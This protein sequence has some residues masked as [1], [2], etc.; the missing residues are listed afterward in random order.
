ME[1]IGN[2]LT[3]KGNSDKDCRK[4]KEFVMNSSKL[5]A[6]ALVVGSSTMYAAVDPVSNWNTVAVQATLTA[7]ESAV[8]QSRT[9]AIVHVAI[10]DA[11]N[12]IDSRYERYAFNA[13]V[14]TG[15]S[16][17]AAIAAAARD[18]LVGAI[19]VGPLP[20]PQFGTPALQA[21][22][23]SQVN[24][25]YAMALAGIPDGAA[26]S[27]GITLGQ[28]AAAAILAL[29]STDHATTLV[30]YTPDTRPGDWQPTPD[31]VPFDP[32]AAADFLPA[33]LPG[34]GQ[35]TPFVLRRSTQFEPDGPPRLSG[36]RYARDY[37][38]VKMIGEKNSAIRTTEQTSIAR[39]WYENSPASW[40]RI[41]IV[42]AHSQ[43]LN[44]WDTA[45]LLALINLAMADGFIAGFETKYDFNF[46][47]PVTAIRAGDTDSNDATIADPNWSSLLNTPAIPDFTS[48]HSV[49]GG[50][51]SEVLRQYF[52]N[53]D[54]PFT[55]TSGVPFA[56][57]T[58]SFSSFSQAA[59]ENGES[60]IYAG[61][62]F[63]SAV[64]DGIQQ[65][66]KI[67]R[68]V[69]THALQPLDQ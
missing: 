48:T 51:T 4:A 53:D 55:T 19:A 28:A 45:R 11:L 20:F 39:F 68:F 60:R 38:E 36:R 13:D 3:Q 47:R 17:D 65:G 49:L 30:T 31:P 9:L 6:I 56:G 14:Q 57:L 21:L 42:V 7:G 12:S 23:V 44:F 5:I 32:P 54:I 66:Q 25:A 63:R 15:A 52:H 69:I 64:E 16:V 29:R 22:A 10:H 43:G 62:H 58:R 37:N 35:V 1:F 50:A 46:W 67:G 34:W 33:A 2:S 8:I 27:D 61:I 59:A 18:A 40:S 41:A 24:T 26:K